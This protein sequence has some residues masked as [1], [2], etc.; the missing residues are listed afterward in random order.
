MVLRSKKREEA[1]QIIT[2][3]PKVCD[4]L[5]TT[6]RRGYGV[7]VEALHGRFALWRSPGEDSKMGSR[8]YRRLRRWKLFF[9]GSLDVFGVRRL[10]QE[11]E[12]RRWPPEGPTRQG[13][14][15][16]GGGALP[17]RGRLDCFLTCTPSP[18]DHV[19]SR[20]IAPEGFIPFGLRLI[21]LFFETLKQARKT[22]IWVGPPVNRLVPKII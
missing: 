18:L 7:D 6:H 16:I 2:M 5:L 13:A 10:I 1:I 14:R 3:D 17:S 11:E 21:F 4:K 9:V 12:V 19:G 15:P 22:T 8:G 20:K